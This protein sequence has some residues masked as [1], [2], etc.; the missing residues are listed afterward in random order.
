MTKLWSAKQINISEMA[1][2]ELSCINHVRLVTSCEFWP[3]MDAVLLQREV[4]VL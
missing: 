1:C 2:V 3:M 4:V